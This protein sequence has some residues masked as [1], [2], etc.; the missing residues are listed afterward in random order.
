MKPVCL[1][2]GLQKKLCQSVR[3]VGLHDFPHC[4]RFPTKDSMT[5]NLP[6]ASMDSRFRCV[7]TE[8]GGESDRRTSRGLVSQRVVVCETWAN[9]KDQKKKTLKPPPTRNGIHGIPF[10]RFLG[11]YPKVQ[12]GFSW[13]PGGLGFYGYPQVTIPEASFPGIQFGIQI[14]GTQTTK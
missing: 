9:W 6:D 11:K 2:G 8:D 5:R 3:H 10:S 14:A 4:V 13:W 7:P 12:L 1:V